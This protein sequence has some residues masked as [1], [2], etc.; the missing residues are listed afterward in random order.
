MSFEIF[1]QQFGDL[2]EYVI[3]EAFTGNRCVIIPQ[4]GGI[5]RQLSLRKGITLFSLLKTP[6]TPDSLVADMKSAS[7]LLFPFASRIPNGRYKF[8]G[9]EYQLAKNETGGLNAIHGLVRK[10][11]F[12]LEDQIIEADH[13]SIKLSYDLN[14]LEGYPF[15]VKFSVLYTLHADGRFVLSYE[16]VNNGAEPAPAMF[17]WHPY[18]VLGNEEVDAWKINI[19]SGEIVDFDNNQIPVGKK[20]FLV[21]RPT[22]LY[23]KAFDNC[24]I[25]DSATTNVVTELISENQ[26]ITLRIKQETGEGKFNYLVVYTPP[27]RDCVA[28]EPLTANVNAFNSGEGLNVL[29]QGKSIH[30]AITLSLV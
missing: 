21:E 28:I 9:K 24:F 5:V 27:A 29:A 4:L 25:V 12:N 17:G 19:P 30:G 10:Q 3:Q 18:F 8:L 1:K 26:D 2:T 20:P 7:E 11:Q 16:A 14:S 23:Q 6:P 22:K 15:S 13:A